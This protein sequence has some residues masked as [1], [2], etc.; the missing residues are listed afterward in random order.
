MKVM[1][2][3]QLISMADALR[4]HALQ[5]GHDL[6]ASNLFVHTMLMRAITADGATDNADSLGDMH[7]WTDA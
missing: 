6:N 7:D 4:S 1:N 5:M 3:Q 2:A